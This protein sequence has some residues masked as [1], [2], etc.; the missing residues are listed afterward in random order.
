MLIVRYEGQ[1]SIPGVPIRGA[2]TTIGRVAGNDIVVSDPRISSRHGRILQN[3][4]LHFYEDLGSRN[5]SIVESDGERKVVHSGQKAAIKS[6]DRLMLG[7]R[8]SPVILEL[9]SDSKPVFDDEDGTI[10]ASRSVIAPVS[11]PHVLDDSQSV[12]ELFTLLHELSGA[13][14]T[15]V[16]FE[17]ISDVLVKRF[18]HAESVSVMMKD[19]SNEWVCEYK[20][21]IDASTMSSAPSKTLLER[22]LSTH[23]IVSYVPGPELD[24]ESVAGLAGAV[25]VPLLAHNQPIGVLHVQ[26]R[27]QAFH[28]DALAWFSI[29]GTHIA[30]SLAAARRFR[31]LAQSEAELKA[32]NNLLKSQVSMPRPIVGKSQTLLTALTQLER[33]G[34]TDTTVLILGETGT[35]KEL[36]ARYVHAHSKRAHEVFNPINCGALPEELLNSELFGH[37]KGAFTGADRDRKGLF[38]SAH[39]GTVFLDEIGEITPAVQVRLLRVLQEREVQPVGTHTPVKV[40][41]RIVA[42]TNRD[43][44]EEVKAGRFRE[45]L[46]YRLAV[47]SVKLPPLR[48]RAGDIGLLAERFREASCARHDMWI[49]GFTEEASRQLAKYQW[50][51]NVRQLEHEIERAV[52]MSSEGELIG[53]D[54]LSDAVV[55]DR[56][57]PETGETLP[58]GELRDVMNILEKRV[59]ERCLEEHGGNR[60]RAAESLG[61]SRQALQVKLAKWRDDATR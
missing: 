37:R 7:D 20:H 2:V 53:I 61:I 32:K 33:V 49:G 59:I 14:E 1:A 42:A 47:F 41:V 24:S 17:R 27:S 12:R 3:G 36:A 57:I 29:V 39:G 34:R 54:E 35:G 51:G 16:V 56:I 8:V 60:T 6:G 58:R 22:A 46:Y 31:A 43:L 25:L 5:G 44:T 11:L 18:K 28:A 45:D 26:S 30:A 50:P 52:I 38:E 13:V 19:V 48:E 10:L 9:H 4:D 40:D 15:D 23:E 55:G 21:T